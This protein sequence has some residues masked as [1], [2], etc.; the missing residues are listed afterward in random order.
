MLKKSIRELE[1]E[2]RTL[3]TNEKKLIADIKKHAKLN[4][5]VGYSYVIPAQVSLQP[6]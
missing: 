4:Q 2:I 5:M 6:S 1:K 3:E